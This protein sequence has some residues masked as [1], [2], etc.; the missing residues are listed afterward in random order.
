MRRIYISYCEA[1]NE[2]ALFLATQLRARGFDV[3]IDY[4][5]IMHN[6][7]SNPRLTDELRSY[8]SVVFLHSCAALHHPLVQ[9]ELAIARE[10]NLP[11]FVLLLEQLDIRA[12]GEFAYL[13]RYDSIDFS[14]WQNRRQAN[15]LLQELIRHLNQKQIPDYVISSSNADQLSQLAVLHGHT[16]WVRTVAFSLNGELL[17]SCGNDKTVCLWDMRTTPTLL[18]VQTAH[19]ASVWDVAFSPTE[20]LLASCGN[21]SVIR[22]WDLENLPQLYELTRFMDHHDPVYALAF[23]PDGQLLASASY[24]NTVHVRDITRVRHTGIADVIVPLLHSSHVYHVA[25]SPDGQLLASAS[26]DSTIRLWQIDRGNLRGLARAKPEF[27]LGH[28]SWVNSVAFAPHEPILASTSHDSTVR[29]WNLIDKQEIG[30]LVGHTASVNTAT[31]S[32]DGRILATTS[33]DNTVRLWDVATQ[34]SIAVIEGHD[35]WVNCAVFSPN[36]C[37]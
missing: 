5:R 15:M 4:E 23:S 34:Q 1:D 13:L 35:R 12:S 2:L 17:A 22:I 33:K 31:F 8:D 27:L 18:D 7:R 29:L 36:G 16:S 32:P 24:D 30:R 9:Q 21:D 6:Q 19:Q 10:L 11:V 20:A 28:M 26:R 14:L 3:W 25:F 37:Y